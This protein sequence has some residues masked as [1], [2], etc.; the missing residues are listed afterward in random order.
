MYKGAEMLRLRLLR[1]GR[2][3][4]GRPGSGGIVPDGVA[5]QVPAAHDDPVQGLVRRES[6]DGFLCI[7]TRAEFVDCLWP[8]HQARGSRLVGLLEVR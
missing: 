5:W 4:T 7:E 6:A 2:W 3:L 1:L 8:E